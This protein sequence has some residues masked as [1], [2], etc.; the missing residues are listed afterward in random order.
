MKGDFSIEA[1]VA[2]VERETAMINGDVAK[3]G[4]PR[5]DPSTPAY[6]ELLKRWEQA[7]KHSAPADQ[8]AP[9]DDPN[10]CPDCGGK[11]RPE[12]DN[13]DVCEKCG[14]VRFY[15]NVGLVPSPTYPLDVYDESGKKIPLVNADGWEYVETVDGQKFDPAYEW[16]ALWPGG[17]WCGWYPSTT[18]R[19]I[20]GCRYGRRLKKS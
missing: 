2:I 7:R 3:Y 10:N 19:M 16:Q 14:S 13:A 17:T 11:M 9:N 6:V 20:A 5:F 4:E 18:A 12:G 1:L 15:G 8:P